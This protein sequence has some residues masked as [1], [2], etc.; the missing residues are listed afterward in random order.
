MNIYM[1]WAK[2]LRVKFMSFFFNWKIGKTEN[3]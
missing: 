3:R 1:L 2:I